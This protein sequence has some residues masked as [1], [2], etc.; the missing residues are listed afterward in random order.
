MKPLSLGSATVRMRVT[1][2]T[3]EGSTRAREAGWKRSLA[4]SGRYSARCSFVP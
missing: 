3:G 1:S 2:K 4:N